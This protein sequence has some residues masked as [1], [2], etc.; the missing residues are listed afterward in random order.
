M[1]AL[2]LGVSD[3]PYSQSK[4]R[5]KSPR[6]STVTTGDVAGWLEDEYHIL[7]HFWQ[8]H[9][10]DVAADVENSLRGAVETMFMGGPVNFDPFGGATSEIEKRMKLFISTQEIELLGY[11]GIPTQ[12]ALRGVNHR[13]KHPYS[14][15]NKRR[16]SFID[17]GLMESSYKAWADGFK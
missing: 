4:A 14:K 16:P 10:P 12:A 7:E 6:A 5:K 11:P 13:K 17:T 2:H 8:Q 9:S 3:V 1:P 15:K